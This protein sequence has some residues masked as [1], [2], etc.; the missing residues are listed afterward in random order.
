[1]FKYKKTTMVEH[2]TKKAFLTKVFNFEENKEWK[3]EGDN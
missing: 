2:L 1:M 3:Y